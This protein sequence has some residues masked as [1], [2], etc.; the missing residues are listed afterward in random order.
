M[1]KR[2]RPTPAELQALLEKW[3]KRAKHAESERKRIMKLGM[4]KFGA[5][6]MFEEAVKQEETEEL[7]GQ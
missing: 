5:K 4:E 6:A 2:R 3:D 7:R 1:S